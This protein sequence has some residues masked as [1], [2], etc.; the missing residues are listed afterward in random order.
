MRSDKRRSKKHNQIEA[1]VSGANTDG[2]AVTKKKYRLNK[3]KFFLFLLAIILLIF[4]VCGAYAAYVISQAPKIDT[5]N[6]YSILTESSVVYDDSGNEIQTVYTDSNRTNVE[7]KDLPKNLVNAV[8]SLEDKT[9]WTHHGFNFVRIFGAMKDALTTH[10]ISGTST[11]TQQLARN[12][13]LPS[14]KSDR[15]I[16]RKIIE[17]Y[18]TVILEKNLSKKQIIEAYLNTIYFGYGCSGVQ[19]A[20]QAYFSKDVK[21]LTLAQCAAL[22]AIPQLPTDYQLVEFVSNSTVSSKNK[23]VLK[24][25]ST[26]T[27]ILNDSSR[28]RRLTC[29]QLMYDQGYIT[30]SQCEKAS[31]RTLR[32]MLKPKYSSSSSKSSYFA[33]YCI[34][35]VIS[36]LEKK[37]NW[38][39]ETAWN[40]VYNG[41]VKIYS[42]MDSTAQNVIENE[43]DNDANFP[44]PTNISYDS[45]GNILNDSGQIVMYDFN[46]YFDSSGNFTLQKSEIVKKNNGDLV[47]RANKRLNIYKTTVSTGTDYSLEFPTMYVYENS[48]LYSISGGYI[49]IPQEYKSLN[50]YGNLV[51][52]SSFFD[53]KDY[54]GFFKFNKD[55]TVTVPSSS[56]TL[57]QEVIQPQAAMT[58]VDNATGQ[59]KAMVGGRKT[60][61]QLLYNRAV[62]TRQPGSSIKPL[63][64]YSA[65]IQQSATEAASGVKH[66][67]YDYHIDT[68][69]T[70]YWGDY[71]TAGSVVIDEKTTINGKVWPSNAGGGYSGVQTM[72]SALQQSINTCAVKIFLQVGA[73]YSANLVKKYGITSLVTSGSVNDMNAAAL[74][75]GGMTKGV[76]TL[77]MADAYTTFP[78]NGIRHTTSSYTKV[79]DNNGDILLENKVGKSVK[80][81]DNGVAWIMCNMLQSVVTSGIGYPAS[82]SGVQVGGKTGTTSDQYDIWFDGFTPSY[83]ASLWI[84]NDVNIELSSMSSY[85]A[86]L[87]GRI[88]NQIPNCKQGSYKSAPSTVISS[89]GEYYINGTQ[90]GDHSVKDTET[91]VT[92]CKDTGF[93]ATPDCPNVE[94]KTYSTYGDDSSSIPQYY[95]NV[96]NPDVNKY[97]ISPDVTLQPATPVTPDEGDDSTDTGNTGT[98]NGTGSGTGTSS[99]NGNTNTGGSTTKPNNGN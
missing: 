26:G 89:G 37:Y 1:E 25:T 65:A 42:T 27:Y 46:D 54:D 30:K 91:T 83:S 35:Q 79:V 69:G 53:D 47:I 93:L 82:I 80:V 22:A 20:S 7:Y 75:L 56:Y 68:Q 17:A 66:S 18:Y 2:T 70:K 40:K 13:F 36:D 9:F 19:A 10:R 50:K 84:G 88:M 15:T 28:D 41:G 55:G 59:I 52:D 58:I 60:T 48:K 72:R 64:V 31:A 16:K 29:L 62:S 78:N 87:W 90:G 99:G 67:F 96:H 24:R 61:G 86:A 77:E 76:S 34:D 3:K 71:L 33:D 51:I 43:F 11:I 39:Y 6:I 74:A 8:V 97:P 23:N 5:D 92:I 85:A 4:I 32:N 21:D 14:E 94:E 73:D 49:N 12:V 57:N 63:A 95:C 38:D 98:G 44:S 45:S 81:L